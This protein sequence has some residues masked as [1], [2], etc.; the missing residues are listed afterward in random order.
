[1]ELNKPLAI[2]AGG[3][4]GIGLSLVRL[5]ADRCRVAVIDLHPP[6]FGESICGSYLTD[7]TSAEAINDTL[8]QIS[9]DH[10]VATQL[11]VTVGKEGPAT[12]IDTD[13]A[14]WDSLIAANLSASFYITRRFVSDLLDAST[15]GSLVL[16]SS[17]AGLVHLPPNTAYAAAKAGIIGLTRDIA[18]AYGPHGIRAN[19]VAPGFVKTPML[20]RLLRNSESR[21]DSLSRRVPLHRIA[22]PEEVAEV[23]SFLLSDGASYVTGAVIPVDGGFTA[24]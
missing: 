18:G 23:I 16:V 22:N 11:A 13:C 14:L 1:M 17:I 15:A 12:L 10:G 20:E 5:L 7:C 9:G 3:A 24:R 2:V 4:S 6:P 8:D 19:V 21:Q